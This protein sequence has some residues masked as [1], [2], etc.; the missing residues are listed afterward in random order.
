M[1]VAVLASLATD[2]LELESS[3]SADSREIPSLQDSAARTRILV[4]DDD[5]VVRRLV[6]RVLAEGGYA[7][8]AAGHGREALEL[9]RS[10]G[11]TVDLAITDIRMP[12]MDGWELGRRLGQRWPGLPI[13][14]LSGY[15]GE[16][17]RYAPAQLA[18]SSFLTKPFNPDELLQR[19]ALLLE[20]R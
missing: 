8:T 6:Q 1:P 15:D 13:I 5:P 16:F 4:V 19:V 18:A 11:A 2:D 17:A 10:S 12:N 20:R 3:W 9:V 14:Y 7:V